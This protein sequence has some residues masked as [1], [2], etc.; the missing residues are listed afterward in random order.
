[1]SDDDAGDKLTASVTGPAVIKYNGSTT[2]PDGVNVDALINPKAVTFD[3]TTADGKA[4]VLHWSYN[5]DHPDLDFLEPGDTLTITYHAQVN[6]GHATTS[7]QA[8]TITLTGTGSSVVQGTAQNDVFD[9]VGGGVTILGHGGSD[10]FVFN[11]NFG[12][13]TVG[14]F[15]FRNDTIV[16]DK[17]MFKDVTDVFAH[18]QSIGFDTVITDANHDKLVLTGVKLADLQAHPGDFHLV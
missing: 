8:L 12:S 16:F 10:T 1:V 14:D 17:S 15:D 4:D 7:D 18:A 3:S 6:D 2:L 11:T 5:P 13:A 9:H